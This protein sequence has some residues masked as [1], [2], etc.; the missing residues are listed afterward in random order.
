MDR[1]GILRGHL[2][3][4]TAPSAPTSGSLFATA[5]GRYKST[6]AGFSLSA[7]T[8]IVLIGLAVRVLVYLCLRCMDRNRRR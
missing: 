5:P 2:E 8:A 7:L 4:G 6:D 3:Q 1:V